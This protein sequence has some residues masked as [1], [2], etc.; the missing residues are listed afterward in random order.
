VRAIA[1]LAE[2][3]HQALALAGRERDAALQ[4]RARVEPRAEAALQLV[5]AERGRPMQRAVP[6]EELVAVAAR[7]VSA[8]LAAANATPG[9]S[10]L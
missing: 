7:P 10:A 2:H 9:Y 8:A 6:A 3:E 1:A 5:A 4:R